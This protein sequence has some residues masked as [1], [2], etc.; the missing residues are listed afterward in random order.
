[1]RLVSFCPAQ[2]DFTTYASN[3]RLD[4]AGAPQGA[5]SPPFVLTISPHPTHR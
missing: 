2:L 1:M 3:V 4:A 5:E